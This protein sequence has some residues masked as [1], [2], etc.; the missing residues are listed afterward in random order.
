MGSFM[1]PPPPDFQPATL[2]GDEQH[3]KELLAGAGVEGAELSC[4]RH[5]SP[6]VHDSP[7][8]WVQY[9]ERVLGPMHM[10]KAALEP[11]GRWEELKD[12]LVTLYSEA[13]EATD[14]SLL[15]QAEYLLTVVKLPG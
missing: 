11:Q 3:V 2:W 10:A 15:A 8:A 9:T 1:P 12:A 4:T 6:V 7:E 5:N 14:G 13:N